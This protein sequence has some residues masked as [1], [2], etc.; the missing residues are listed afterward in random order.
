MKIRDDRMVLAIKFHSGK[1]LD[2]AIFKIESCQIAEKQIES[3][4]TGNPIA[5]TITSNKI[6]S[7]HL[8]RIK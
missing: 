1:S 8:R 7:D 2:K 3:T 5:D 6:W 4:R